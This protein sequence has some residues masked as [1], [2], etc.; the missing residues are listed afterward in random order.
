M[1]ARLLWRAFRGRYRDNRTELDA[2]AAAIRPTDI[3]CDIGANKGSYLYWLSRWTPQGR[4]I[5]FEPQPELASY[6][7][8]SFR[9]PRFTNVTVEASGV[10]G[11]SGSRSLYLPSKNSPGATLNA[12]HYPAGT[13]SVTVPVV[14]LDDYFGAGRPPDILKIDVEGAELEVFRGAERILTERGPLLVFECEQRHLDT[15][16]VFDVFAYLELFGYTGKFV[17]GR[18]LS[19]IAGFSLD[20]HQRQTGDCFWADKGYCNNFVF[21]KE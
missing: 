10:G 13:P 5:A 2:I 19:P 17:N 7:E 11:S 3:V 21:Q 15:G 16:S 12:K 6:L 18:S 14:A 20:Q 8:S 1:A 4:V 9:A